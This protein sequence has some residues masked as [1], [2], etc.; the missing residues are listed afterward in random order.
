M[1]VFYGTI[2]ISFIER[3]PPLPPTSMSTRVSEL[4]VDTCFCFSFGDAG[5]NFS[6]MRSV[7]GRGLRARGMSTR[8]CEFCVVE[9]SCCSFVDA[10]F[11]YFAR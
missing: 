3:L 5:F 7:R 1:L 4:C 10:G 2:S 9:C 8:V 11:R 6:C